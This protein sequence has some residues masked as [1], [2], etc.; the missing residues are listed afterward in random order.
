MGYTNFPNGITSFGVPVAF[1]P[2][3]GMAM[4]SQVYFVDKL[5]GSDGNNGKNPDMGFATIE[6]A[7]VVA[8]AYDVIYVADPGTTSSDPNTYSGAAANYIVPVASKGLAIIG[9][10]HSAVM[11][12]GRPMA[13]SIY[14]YQA[15]TPIFTVNAA[16]VS[17]ENFRIAGVWDAGGVET[18]GIYAPDFSEGVAEGF[19]LSVHNCYFE[20]VNSIGDLGAIAITGQWNGTITNCTFMNC[21]IGISIVSSGST[22]VGTVIDRVKFLSRDGDGSE[23]KCDIYMYAQGATGILIND[24]FVGHDCP[25]KTGTKG[26]CIAAAA[27]TED[28]LIT[29][30]YFLDADGTIHATTGTAIRVPVT[31]GVSNCFNGDNALMA[32]N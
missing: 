2:S 31:M 20:D 18:G 15:A 6:R 12:N 23:I 7:L 11:G 28:G 10:A 21:E 3:F 8:G 16:Q 25:T 4:N 13:P 9:I 26:A 29:N 27:G 14:A 22:V 5:N 19:G 24:V 1:G 30:A 17:I 32:A